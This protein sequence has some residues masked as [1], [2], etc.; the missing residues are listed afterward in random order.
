MIHLIGFLL[1]VQEGGRPR[2]AWFALALLTGLVLAVCGLYVVLDRGA[3]L[4]QRELRMLRHDVR[5]ARERR[6]LRRSARLA[7]A[8]VVSTTPTRPAPENYPAPAPTVLDMTSGPTVKAVFGPVARQAA[9]GTR[10]PEPL[11]HRIP[12]TAHHDPDDL[13][14][15]LSAQQA[16]QTVEDLIVWAR[17]HPDPDKPGSA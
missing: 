12:E 6:S 9:E 16:R 14:A 15:G 4:L 13:F 11:P 3:R 17:R 8:P 10:V 1:W 7:A 5:R 2:V